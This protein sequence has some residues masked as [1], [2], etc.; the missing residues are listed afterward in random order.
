[1]TPPQQPPES[2]V[3]GRVSKLARRPHRKS[4]N[5]CFNCKRRKVKCDEVK[6]ACSNCIRFGIPCDFAPPPPPPSNKDPAPKAVA[7]EFVANQAGELST[8]PRRG[9]GRPRKDWAALAK[10]LPQPTERTG[11]SPVSN[12]TTPASTSTVSEPIVCSFNVA[13]A[14]LLL[15][16][17]T[18]TASSL[19]DSEEADSS[20]GRFWERNVPQIGLSY[21]FVLH[22]SYA[23][24]GYHLA[25]SE[26]GNSDRHAQ[27]LALARHHSETGLAELNKTLPSLDE[28]NCGA[29]YVSA[30]LVCYCAFAAGPT[31]ATDLL[32]C[33]VDD[34]APQRW[35]P[36]IHGVR[37]IRQ[38]VEPATLFTGLMEPLGG[39][40]DRDED[41]RPMYLI[42]GFPHVEWVEPV[43][44]LQ[45]WIESYDTPDTIIYVR[46]L[47]SLTEIYEAN[48]GGKSG[49]PGGAT[50]NKFVFGWLYR[51]HDLFV[52][53]LQRKEPQALLIMA[54][55]VPL[56]RTLK[57]CWFI[58]GWSKHLLGTIRG[59][60]NQDVLGWL[61]WPVQIALQRP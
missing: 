15:Y 48:Y 31:G 36:L 25:F 30:V 28:T 1:M 57:K 24:A 26:T 29:L 51:M 50:H 5:G 20:I 39:S 21:H 53:C 12:V 61:E 9:P 43:E 38:T 37:L 42:G 13:D 14:E 46:A 58:D 40:P 54:Y 55:Y 8:A 34:S 59:M 33:N 16:F 11:S 60:L 2:P 19:H 18:H 27:Y 6:P 49:I 32:V 7:V 41:H 45:K 17:V 56:L 22:L 52:A 44:K 10:P 35:L 3:P 47:S 23:L 4:R